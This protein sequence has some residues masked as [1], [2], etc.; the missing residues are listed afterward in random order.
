[1]KISKKKIREIRQ[2]LQDEI[3]DVDITDVEIICTG[4]R[5]YEVESFSVNLD[6]DQITGLIKKIL[7]RKK[8]L[9]VI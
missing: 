5:D 6:A 1:M 8:I 9:E 2:L 7:E 3:A 4:Y